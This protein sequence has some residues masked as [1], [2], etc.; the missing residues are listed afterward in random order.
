MINTELLLELGTIPNERNI[1]KKNVVAALRENY[2]FTE[3]DFTSFDVSDINFIAEE[4]IEN[5]CYSEEFDEYYFISNSPFS[6]YSELISILYEA[7]YYKVP[8]AKN[9]NRNF[10]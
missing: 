4:L 10:I 6:K 3:I 7:K 2:F 1:G 5:M 8:V 9:K